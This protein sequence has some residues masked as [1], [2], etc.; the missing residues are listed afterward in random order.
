MEESKSEIDSRI[1][2]V[3]EVPGSGRIRV[4]ASVSRRLTESAATED[5]EGIKVPSSE[6][7]IDL[8]AAEY[9]RLRVKANDFVV[10]VESARS[11][12]LKKYELIERAAEWPSIRDVESPVAVSR[13]VYNIESAEQL[14]EDLRARTSSLE[15]RFVPPRTDETA[16]YVRGSGGADP[17]G[18][19]LE[20]AR[21]ILRE[22]EGAE[23][24]VRVILE[25]S[26]SPHNPGMFFLCDDLVELQLSIVESPEKGR[27]G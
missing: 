13:I 20:A 16:R 8:N 19:L 24:A 23:E 18:D 25:R 12:T 2:A 14:L 9:G 7:T 15:L 4:P 1:L 17:D 6:K 3:R 22:P 5:H 10:F 21:S 26:E 27:I 11:I